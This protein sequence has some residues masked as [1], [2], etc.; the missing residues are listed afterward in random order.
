MF[1]RF[2]FCLCLW[3][4]VGVFADSDAVKSVS[5]MEGDSVSLQ[6]NTKLLAEDLIT[7]TFGR[8][9]TPIAQIDKYTGRFSTYDVLDGRFRERLK[10]D[11]Q[12][13]SLTITNT[14]TTDSGLYQVTIKGMTDTTYRFNVAVSGAFADSDAVKSLMQGDSVTL[15]T[16]TELHTEYWITWTFGHSETRIAHINKKYGMFSLYDV[17]DGKFRDRLKLDLQTGS[18]T[19]TNTRTTDSGLYEVMSLVSHNYTYSFNVTVFGA[20][21]DSD[22]VKSLSVMEGNS[23]TLQTNTELQ[24]DDEITWT[25]GHPETRIAHI[26]K[27]YGMFSLYDVLDG[28][29]RDRLKLDLQTGSLIITNTTTTDT[30][31]YEVTINGTKQTSYRFNVTVFDYV[32]DSSDSVCDCDSAEAVIRLVLSALVGMAAVAAFVVLV[33]DI[34]SRRAGKDS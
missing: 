18:L 31:L 12:T 20:F 7:W 16:N 33:Y 24:T 17:L 25:F 23:V 8:P 5:V 32:H 21:A 13:G 34:R 6:T 2:W 29:F 27:K 11:L 10:L 28:K 3:H 9:K 30:G 26:Y 15:Q 4:L 14:R 19:I 1:D 22:A